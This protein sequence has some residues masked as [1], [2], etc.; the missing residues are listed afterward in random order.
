MLGGFG[1]TFLFYY[2]GGLIR[3]KLPN[4]KILK[5][6]EKRVK[7]AVPRF[8]QKPFWSIFISK[9]II[10]TNWIVMA[11]AG[12]VKVDIKKYLKA[13]VASTIIWAP[14]LLCLGYFFSFTAFSI[15][16][17][18]SKFSL[19]ILILVVLFFLIDKF[20]AWLY[21]LFEEFHVEI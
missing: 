15:S 7:D 10:G 2:F 1:K 21:E 8:S 9:F 13:E 17:E 6:I 5:F 16:K 3:R 4:A 19:I 11:Y 12:F 14:S 20:I 18:I